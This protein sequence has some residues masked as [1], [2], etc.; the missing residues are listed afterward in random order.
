[1][2]K[3]EAKLTFLVRVMICC[4]LGSTMLSSTTYATVSGSHW[5]GTLKMQN[6]KKFKES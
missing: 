1:M 6:Q 2:D 4:V 5:H 3:Y